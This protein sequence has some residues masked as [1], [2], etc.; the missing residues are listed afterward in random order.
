MN[1]RRDLAG[2]DHIELFI[3]MMSVDRAASPKTIRNY[4]R[5]LHRYAASLERRGETVV[6]AGANDISAFLDELF[7]QGLSASSAALAA[8]AIRQLHLFLYTEGYRD[9][10]PAALVDRPKTRRPLPKVLSEEET[11]GLIAAAGGDDAES[12]RLK[13][14]IELLYGS[15]LRV[16]ELVSLPLQGFD[17]ETDAII[18][19]GKGGK[20]RLVP[21]SVAGRRAV[22]RYLE[23]RDEFLP[24]NKNGERRP[25]RF[26]FPSR[27]AA[28]HLTPARLAQ[29]LK[30]L[31]SRAGIDPAKVS[32]HVLRHAFAT[33]LVSHGA[34]LRAV[35]SMLG[36]ADIATTEIY[37]HV[38]RGR[39]KD[40]VFNAH[41]LAK[42][43][44]RK[45]GG[46]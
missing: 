28:G 22:D 19:R 40:L 1:A 15:G 26:L 45:A 30:A 36:H 33:D 37:T 34:N 5:D 6:T 43:T 31:A 10:N 9:D 4:R 11:A 7:Q 32:P 39:L 13:A 35:Q 8:S 21:V 24:K 14:L 23:V 29:L 16:S 2:C 20:E 25:S 18:I 46:A 38:A 12:V 41:P 44:F 27:A 42:R 3:E 17:D